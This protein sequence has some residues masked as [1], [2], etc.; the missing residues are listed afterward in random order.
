MAA[1]L[2]MD[3]CWFVDII[4]TFFTA[5]KDPHTNRLEFRKSVLASKYLKSWFALDVFT[6][7]PWTVV[8]VAEAGSLGPASDGIEAKLLQ[9]LK[10]NQ[11][12]RLLRLFKLVQHLRVCK[13][14]A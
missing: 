1:E 9:V 13:Y 14:L 12:Y 11:L 4:L 10:L 3:A 7:F 6:A 2:L 5:V 8:E